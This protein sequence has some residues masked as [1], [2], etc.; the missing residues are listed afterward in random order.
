VGKLKAAVL[1]AH[2]KLDDRA[3]IEH[4]LRLKK[5]M[6]EAGKPY[7]WL[8]F[9]DETHGFYSPQNR[10]LYYRQLLAFLQQHL[11]K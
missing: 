4:A 10:E 9:D 1:I 11:K 7:Q 8:E 2:G 6:D 3:P 5:A